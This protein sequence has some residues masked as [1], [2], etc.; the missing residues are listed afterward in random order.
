MLVYLTRTYLIRASMPFL[1]SQSGALSLLSYWY[2]L[3]PVLCPLS[4]VHARLMH[5]GWQHS[6]SLPVG[7]S[8]TPPTRSHSPKVKAP[9][10]NLAPPKG[11]LSRTLPAPR[12]GPRN[13]GTCSVVPKDVPCGPW[14]AQHPRYSRY[15]QRYHPQ[16]AQALAV[17]PLHLAPGPVWGVR[18]QT[19]HWWIPFRFHLSSLLNLHPVPSSSTSTPTNAS[20]EEARRPICRPSSHSYPSTRSSAASHDSATVLLPPCAHNP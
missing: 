10:R 6:A 9:P 12:K 20:L 2:S 5:T 4:R 16:P 14:R 15:R 7:R 3:V 1:G 8:C 18:A 11:C 17:A 19:V 13:R